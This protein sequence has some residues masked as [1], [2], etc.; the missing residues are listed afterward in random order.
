LEDRIVKQFFRRE[1]RDCI[2]PP[3]QPV[4]TCKHKA[5]LVEINRRPIEAAEEETESNPRARSARLRVVERISPI[6]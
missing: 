6:E 3:E 4:C 5:A 1:S 2:C